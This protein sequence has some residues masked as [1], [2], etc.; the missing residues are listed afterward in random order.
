MILYLV[1]LILSILIFPFGILLLIIKCSIKAKS[2]WHFWKMIDNHFRAMAISRDMYANVWG[3]YF[4]NSTMIKSG[5]YK[6][7][8]RKET[9]SSVYGKNLLKSTLTGL[10]RWVNRRLNKIDPNHSINSIDKQI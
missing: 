8:N 3:K 7:G 4:F 6:F 2:L 10:G 9:L 1:S 5:G